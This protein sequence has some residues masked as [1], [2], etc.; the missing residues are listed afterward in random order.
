MAYETKLRQHDKAYDQLY[1]CGKC[2]EGCE[3]CND[4]SPCLASYN[5]TFRY[6][7]VYL[8]SS[9]QV[10]ENSVLASVLRKVLR[11]LLGL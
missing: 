11:Q 7:Q 8:L 2:Q 6:V 4:D 3:T 1:V 5:W 10:K 9:V